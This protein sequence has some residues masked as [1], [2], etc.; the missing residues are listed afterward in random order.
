LKE[1]WEHITDAGPCPELEK[2]ILYHDGKL[3]GDERFDVENH[4]AD[5]EICNDALEGYS[6]L[7]NEKSLAAAETDLRGRLEKFLFPETGKMRSFPVYRRL[8]VA[9]S[10]LLLMGIGFFIYEK[11]KPSNHEEAVLFTIKKEK[12]QPNEKLANAPSGPQKQEK[13]DHKIALNQDQTDKNIANSRANR[14]TN[15]MMKSM[16]NDEVMEED[17]SEIPDR[18]IRVLND[19]VHQGLAISSENPAVSSE[20]EMPIAYGKRSGSKTRILSGIIKDQSGRP[21]PGANVYIKNSK[22]ATVADVNGKFN[23]SVQP[24][25]KN[26]VVSYIGFASQD[27]ALN[28]HPKLDITLNEEVTALNEMVVVGYGTQKKSEVSGSVA[29]LTKDEDKNTAKSRKRNTVAVTLS[30]QEIAE[31]DSIKRSLQFDSQNRSK[32]KSLAQK[33]IELQY[34]NEAIAQLKSLQQFSSDSIELEKV[35]D[36]LLLVQKEKYGKALKMLKKLEY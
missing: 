27:I 18:K 12:N 26:L 13:K 11:L 32:I 34:Q 8:M 9:A 10:I 2:L 14:T 24:S 23:I 33:Y 7:K 15:Q 5:C 19:T 3:V 36:I 20:K 4:L 28:D 21:L 1:K 35:T 30:S 16:A 6:L 25:D 29:T 17:R 22:T 31:L